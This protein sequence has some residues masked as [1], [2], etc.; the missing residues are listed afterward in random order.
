[1]N[2]SGPFVCFDCAQSEIYNN[3]EDL[4]AHIASDHLNICPYEC[5]K[6]KYAKFPTEFALV[7]H[8]MNDH[9]LVEF[10]IKYRYTPELSSKKKELTQK[11]EQCMSLSRTV[12]SGENTLTNSDPVSSTIKVED[13]ESGGVP[14]FAPT[15]PIIFTDPISSYH[16]FLDEALSRHAEEGPSGEIVDDIKDEGI[17][18]P[19]GTKRDK[20]K[21]KQQIKCALCNDI[22]SRQR[23]SMVYHANTR[24]GKYE[25]Y[26]CGICHRKW[27][28]IAKSDVIKHIK[29]HHEQPDGSVNIDMVIDYR[30]NL[31]NKLKEVTELCFPE[32]KKRRIGYT[33]VLE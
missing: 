9:G 32:R 27:Q 30:K 16:A 17:T 19:K 1:M 29:S 3:L 33:D 13:S 23:S 28:T 21:P 2:C 7:S 18:R 15:S 24:H 22:V 8:C 11:L 25:L 5:E 26:E 14:S 4:E 31:G 10:S 20:E 12:R 6:C